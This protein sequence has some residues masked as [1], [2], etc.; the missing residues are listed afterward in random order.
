MQAP[1]AQGIMGLMAQGRPPQQPQQPQQP[2]PSPMKASPMAGIGSVEDRVAA[3]RGN[4]APL[5][6]R[7]AM[8]Q[9]LLDLLALQKIKSEKEAAARQMQLAMGQQAAAQ[10]AEPP[11]IAQQREQ[12]VHDLTKNEL[13]QQ[14]GETAQ[15]QQAQQQEAMKRA[16]SGGVAAAPG[17]QAAAQPKMMAA[18]GIVA[19][20]EGGQAP[21]L[22]T[23][24]ALDAARERRRIAQ[25]RLQTFGLRQRQQSPTLFEMAKQEL[26]EAEAAL[27]DAQKAYSATMSAAGLD[28]P[29]T[30]R[31]DLGAAGR[32]QRAEAQAFPV[33][34]VSG[35]ERRG[36]P[37]SD[38]YP[39]ETRRGSAAGLAAIPRGPA[40]TVTPAA[41][42]PAQ[43]PPVAPVAPVAPT[44]PAGPAGPAM[45]SYGNDMNALLMQQAKRDTGAERL[46]EEGRVGNLLAPPEEQLQA[47]RDANAFRKREFESQYDPERQR[48]EGLIRFLTGAGGRRYGELGAGAQ[49]GMAYDT[50]QRATKLKEFDDMQKGIMQPFDLK[51][52]ALEKGISAG[53]EAGKQAGESQRSGIAGLYHQY[54]TDVG[55]RDKALD[56][57]AQAREKGLDREV[58]RL[59]IDLQGETN[60][61]SRENLGFSKA[62]AIYSAATGRVQELERKLDG[63]F[64]KQYGMLL[65]AEQGGKMEPAQKQQLEVART[66]LEI[67]KD[68]IRKELEPVLA[69]ARS[70]LGIT[71]TSGWGELK[72]K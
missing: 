67:K 57:D 5:Q 17:A 70:K 4:P 31:E 48:Q 25:E 11:T 26:A 64:A 41:A 56:R 28:R 12:E 69:S 42:Q 7:Y 65:M 21:G 50:Q 35:P 44:T 45:P 15:Q 55:S 59:K 66:Q 61:I 30:R 71:S 8:S 39:D 6:Q 34:G 13:A 58:E 2:M 19:F 32:Y 16:L 52:G 37:V 20:Q 72:T 3:Y 23:G 33:S 36:P 54:G 63:D 68:Q 14:R 24:P 1:N 46:A 60:R 49:A 62:Q 53:Q 38:V 27:T 43:R 51:R 10:G 29:M 40:P 47:I 18:G 22:E 9:D